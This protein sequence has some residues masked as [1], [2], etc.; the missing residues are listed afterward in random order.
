MKT[1]PSQEPTYLQTLIAVAEDCPV[2]KAAVPDAPANNNKPSVA[3]IQYKMLSES[4]GTLTQGDVLF[5]TWRQRQDAVFANEAT[6]RIHFFSTAQACLRCSPLSKRHGWG[7]LFDAQ[8]RITLCKV[9]SQEYSDI[10]EGRT[11]GIRVVYALR[12][13]KATQ[14]NPR[15]KPEQKRPRP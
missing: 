8:G 2:V 14:Q 11:P 7:L 1:R 4:P 5:Q 10:M 15:I 13:R 6:A 3:F 12:T 9:E